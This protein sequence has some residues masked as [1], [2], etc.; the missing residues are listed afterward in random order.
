MAKTFGITNSRYWCLSQ[1]FA[2]LNHIKFWFLEMFFINFS[3]VSFILLFN[4]FCSI[5]K[6]SLYAYFL[7]LCLFWGTNF[8]LI[9]WSGSSSTFLKAYRW[10]K[11]CSMAG[12]S[13]P[14]KLFSKKKSFKNWSCFSA[15]LFWK[16]GL[17]RWAADLVLRKGSVGTYNILFINFDW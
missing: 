8:W 5:N 7:F 4:C 9:I 15:M 10:E 2:Y 17:F 12:S 3:L 11:S 13:V 6:R 16:W 14:S 1:S